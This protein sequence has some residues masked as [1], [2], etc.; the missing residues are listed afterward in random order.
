MGK[1]N[2]PLSIA[3]LACC[4]VM[5]TLDR[6]VV[7]LFVEPIRHSLG[8]SD[9]QIALVQGPAFGVLYILATLPFG[10]LADITN[11]KNII[12]C[13]VALWS[14]GTAATGAAWSY[15]TI[16]MARIVVGAGE[17]GLTP[18]AYSMLADMVEKR[19]L[20]RVIAFF[21]MGGMVGIAAAMLGGGALVRALGPDGVTFPGVGNVASWRVVFLLMGALGLALS[22]VVLRFVPEPAR[23][24]QDSLTPLRAVFAEIWQHRSFYLPVYIGYGFLAISNYGYLSWLPT[25]F[26][27]TY[28]LSLPFVGMILG[29]GFLISNILGPLAGGWLTDWLYGRVGPAAAIIMMRILF[30]ILIPATILTFTTDALHVAVEGCVLMTF[31]IAALLALGPAAIQMLAPSRMRGQLGAVLMLCATLLG[32]TTGP[33]IVAALAQMPALSGL[34][35]AIGIHVGVGASLGLLACLTV[36]AVA[37]VSPRR[38]AE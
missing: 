19:K 18:P 9:L 20:A 11:R 2:V 27:R 22:F 34:K 31:V 12:G 6:S 32:V 17:A 21:T 25:Y 1:A 7:S 30:A 15:V 37:P 10:R 14:V 28:G 33:V 4:N 13:A 36:R 35:G 8:L 24:S 38:T 26:L 16:L 29:V 5:S 23:L 3:L